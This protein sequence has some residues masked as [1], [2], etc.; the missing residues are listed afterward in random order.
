[1]ILREFFYHDEETDHQVDDKRYSPGND[2]LGMM[3][4]GDTRKTR[5]TLG[6][7]NRARRSTEASEEERKKE[8]VNVRQM[9]AAQNNQEGGL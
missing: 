8:L 3:R 1:M 7:I 2:R 6:Q 5:L 9:Y 4:R